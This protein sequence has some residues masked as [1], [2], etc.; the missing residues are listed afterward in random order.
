MSQ[1]EEMRKYLQLYPNMQQV[2]IGEPV[3]MIDGNTLLN[4]ILIFPTEKPP[5][6]LN[7]HVSDSIAVEA[8][9]GGIKSDG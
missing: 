8:H 9:Y 4:V 6:D 5:P 2:K 1:I 3:D 7:I